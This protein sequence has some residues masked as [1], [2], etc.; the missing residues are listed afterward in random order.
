MTDYPAVLAAIRPGAQYTLNGDLYAG[1]TWLDDS[2]K[3]TQKTLD[4]AW[5]QVQYDQQLAAVKAARQARYQAETD[6]MFMKVQRAEDGITLDDW[7][8]AVDAIRADLPE[9][10]AP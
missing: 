6:P 8:A 9:P 3:P 7:K 1:L 4:D 2:P 10:T 5:P